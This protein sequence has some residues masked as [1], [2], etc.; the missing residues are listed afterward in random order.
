MIAITHILNTNWKRESHLKKYLIVGK[1]NYSKSNLEYLCIRDVSF[2]KKIYVNKNERISYKIGDT[3]SICSIKGI[4]G[5]EHS[6][7]IRIID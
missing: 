3:I 2:E 1:S 4:L 5:I 7:T 6:H